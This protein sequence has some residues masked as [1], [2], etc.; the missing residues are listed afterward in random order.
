MTRP[1][2]RAIVHVAERCLKQAKSFHVIPQL[3]K[4]NYINILLCLVFTLASYRS[5]SIFLLTIYLVP[6][7]VNTFF[8][9]SVKRI[10]PYNQIL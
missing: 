5:Y 9:D 7:M 1:T 6:K 4:R 3:H 8:K 2:C 10:L